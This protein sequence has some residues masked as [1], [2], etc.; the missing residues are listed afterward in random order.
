MTEGE[1]GRASQ[2]SGDLFTGIQAML[3][4]ERM[5]LPVRMENLWPEDH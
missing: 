5:L 2:K 1:A 4:S 3:Y